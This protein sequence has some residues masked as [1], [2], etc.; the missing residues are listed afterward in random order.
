MNAYIDSVKQS[1]GDN[2]NKLLIDPA[3]QSLFA[4]CFTKYVLDHLKSNFAKAI[5]RA[6]REDQKPKPPVS[7][8][9]DLAI[10]SKLLPAD[11]LVTSATDPGGQLLLKHPLQPKL[12]GLSDRLFGSLLNIVNVS[13]LV[14]IKAKRK[15]VISDDVK[16]AL[17]LRG[18]PVVLSENNENMLTDT[19]DTKDTDGDGH[20]SLFTKVKFSSSSFL[21]ANSHIHVTNGRITI[22]D[23]IF[24]VNDRDNITVQ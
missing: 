1:L 16:H 10:K 17:Q 19:K 24:R 9:I 6:D 3:A 14:A 7:H 20:L 23:F 15:A 12:N 4:G 22:H 2:T 8:V 18:Y 21:P 5:Q 11:A 13:S